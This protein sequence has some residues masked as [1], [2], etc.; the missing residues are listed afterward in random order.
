MQKTVAAL[1]IPYDGIK[2]WQA[3][4]LES[5]ARY[6][7]VSQLIRV[8]CAG[9]PPRGYPFGYRVLCALYHR[10]AE[11]KAAHL[12]IAHLAQRSVLLEQGRAT[13]R[14]PDAE[15]ELLHQQGVEWI[16]NFGAPLEPP[17]GIDIISYQSNAPLHESDGLPGLVE[18]HH[19]A[20]R[21]EIC[22]ERHAASASG[23]GVLA[24]GYSRVHGDS[25]VRTLGEFYRSAALLLK[26]ALENL[27]SRRDCDITEAR[28]GAGPDPAILDN[29]AVASVVIKATGRYLRG[30]LRLTLMEQ[31]GSSISTRFDTL[32]ELTTLSIRPGVLAHS[33]GS[34]RE[35]VVPP[36][37]ISR[38]GHDTHTR[39]SGTARASKR[40]GGGM[41]QGET[42]RARGVPD[43]TLFWHGGVFYLFAN[44]DEGALEHCLNLY[45][46]HELR[47]PFVAHPS[48]PIVI[49]P[50]SARM[51]GRIHVDEGRIYRFGR[52]SCRGDGGGLTVSEILT[53]SPQEYREKRVGKLAFSDAFGPQSIDIDGDRV[54]MHFFT[55]QIALIAGYRRLMT[56][57]L[58]RFAQT[59]KGDALSA[60]EEGN[61]RSS[62]QEGYS[63]ARAEGDGAGAIVEA[64]VPEASIAESRMAE[65]RMA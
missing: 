39:L 1:A 27:R 5:V 19:A 44:D 59:E 29:L 28:Q 14:L 9:Q 64:S 10:S 53:L 54:E 3:D 16:I 21:I 45:Y 23:R 63:L 20:E 56:R 46:S 57:L 40:H 31:H 24:R 50:C 26:P 7:Q 2:Q 25:L 15:V 11:V 35:H 37:P 17:P 47:G 30:L 34:Q 58:H 62:L 12:P 36:R 48:S 18:L 22:I 49:D 33:G 42:F 55:E 52:D 41:P 32:Q 6:L 38:P 61:G 51:G 43:G 65:S 8:K 60:T 13:S 4:A